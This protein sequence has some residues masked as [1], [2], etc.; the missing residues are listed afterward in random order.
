MF[1]ETA[2]DDPRQ[3][4]TAGTP[5]R[6]TSV[7]RAKMVNDRDAPDLRLVI[8]APVAGENARKAR[9]LFAE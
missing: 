3:T 4:V 6:V 2:P 8:S 7:R 5:R 1:P 9:R